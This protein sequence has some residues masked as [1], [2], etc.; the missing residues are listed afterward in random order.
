MAS[1]DDPSNESMK[2]TSLRSES[3]DNLEELCT[4][5]A[6]V[7]TGFEEC[8]RGEA[9][10]KFGTDVQASRGKIIWKVPLSQLNE[11]L[12]M[13]SVD[14]CR[15]VIHTVPHFKFSDQNDSLARLQ[16]MILDVNWECG[17][18]AWKRI[19]GFPYSIA[20]SPDVIP[21]PEEL[22][23]VVIMNRQSQPKDKF[24]KKKKN[25]GKGRGKKKEKESKEYGNNKLD[26]E[27]QKEHNKEESNVDKDSLGSGDHVLPE[28]KE[29][30][31]E[32]SKLGPDLGAEDLEKLD[33]AGE[34]STPL[35]KDRNIISFQKSHLLPPPKTVI[36]KQVTSSE[37]EAKIDI[38]VLNPPP[39][40]NVFPSVLEN[41]ELRHLEPMEVDSPNT[42]FKANI[43]SHQKPTND[44]EVVPTS[45]NAPDCA[46]VAANAAPLSQEDNSAFDSLKTSDPESSDAAAEA[47]ATSVINKLSISHTSSS[48]ENL[49]SAVCTTPPSTPIASLENPFVVANGEANGHPEHDF[50]AYVPAETNPKGDGYSSSVDPA[51]FF[52]SSKTSLVSTP[53]GLSA[54]DSGA[55]EKSDTVSTEQS[56]EKHDINLVEPKVTPCDQHQEIVTEK[57][58]EEKRLSDN[59]TSVECSS[60]ELPEQ[61]K[62]QTDQ[63]QTITAVKKPER[64]RDPTKPKFR[65]TCNRVGNHSFDSASAAASFGSAVITYFKWPVDLK[66]FD[67]EILLNIDNEEVTV[68]L[69]LTKCSLHNR[70][71]VAFGPTTLRSTIC[72]NMLRLCRI[73][74][75]D[76]ICD[77]MC[78][79]SAIPI[80]SAL[81]W[82]NCYV[83]G[84]DFHEKAIERTATNIKAIE[85]KQRENNRLGSRTVNRTLYPCLLTEMARTAR[86]GARACLLT[87]DRTSLIKAIQ[88][89]S[90]FWQRRL[91]LNVNIGGLSGFVFVLLR[92]TASQTGHTVKETVKTDVPVDLGSHEKTEAK[93]I[94]TDI[95]VST[96]NDSSKQ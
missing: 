82:T 89:L 54:S 64:E 40:E 72:Y 39:S 48:R 52:P 37:M 5:E 27:N 32:E 69:A 74:K 44:A 3:D 96:E 23:D 56:T 70:N 57:A 75:G 6:S 95:Q 50:E 83:F 88:S 80:E 11:V 35:D 28:S 21:S 14:N 61:D 8:A 71:M 22:V 16:K 18:K 86:P 84:G 59:L 15:V 47:F 73:K 12:K 51:D 34:V 91:M 1:P 26:S 38:K 90:K 68:S 24:G 79:T 41:K 65:V 17:L 62:A 2:K 42:S 53:Q 9:R 43:V 45:L 46:S 20:S 85:Q 93:S 7:V 10:E 4:V 36:V 78:G 49:V 77:P 55:V 13:G 31:C 92:T 94:E 76:F 19:F 63:S 33:L 66:N 81:N 60:P 29:G 25:L 30:L 67:I 58:T 87:E